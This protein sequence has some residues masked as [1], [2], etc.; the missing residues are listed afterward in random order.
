[1][2]VLWMQK[3][4]IHYLLSLPSAHSL[5][6]ATGLRGTSHQV[7]KYP[8]CTT[9]PLHGL[10]HFLAR[11]SLLSLD[12]TINP[13]Q[14]FKTSYSLLVPYHSLVFIALIWLCEIKSS[15]YKWDTH[16]Q[17][18]SLCRAVTNSWFR[19]QVD[20]KIPMAEYLQHYFQRSASFI[21]IWN[22]T[23]CKD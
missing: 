19:K 10:S 13:T 23:N 11:T 18:H 17:R 2:E 7:E 16:C 9:K 3:T 5:T 22:A 15:G 20:R 6:Q 4:F 8:L 1:M 14:N 12:T 21:N